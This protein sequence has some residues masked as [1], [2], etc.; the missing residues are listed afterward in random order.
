MCSQRIFLY[1][2][3]FVGLYLLEGQIG[4]FL[5]IIY[6]WSNRNWLMVWWSEDIII[7]S[8]LA[9]LIVT[10]HESAIPVLSDKKRN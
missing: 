6:W 2:I 7:G 4:Y 10:W 1:K 9:Y 8:S 5:I 3:E